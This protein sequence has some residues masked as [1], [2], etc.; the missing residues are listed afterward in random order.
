MQ[1]IWAFVTIVDD[2]HPL[3]YENM[4]LKDIVSC[5]CHKSVPWTPVNVW[6][7]IIY[8]YIYIYTHIYACMCACICAHTSICVYTNFSVV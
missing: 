7:N 1:M 3:W 8:C 6:V 4:T 5:S 2:E